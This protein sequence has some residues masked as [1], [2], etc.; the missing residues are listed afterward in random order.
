[1]LIGYQV[2]FLGTRLR[3]CNGDTDCDYRVMDGHWIGDKYD[4]ASLC[5]NFAF[6]NFTSRTCHKA[7]VNPGNDSCILFLWDAVTF[8]N[9]S[10]DTVVL[11]DCAF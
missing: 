2:F 8:S 5:A 11:S 4:C 3:S 10:S 1:M 7:A 9:T 6:T